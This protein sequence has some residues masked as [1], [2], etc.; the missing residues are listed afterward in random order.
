MHH[1]GVAKRVL[2]YI[3]G[4]I[5]FGIWYFNVSD[6]RLSGFTDSDWAGCL[7]GRKCTCG[8]SFSLDSGAVSWKSKKQEIVAH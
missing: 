6:F 3:A 8:Y 2:R 1:L 4:T 7:E 5:D